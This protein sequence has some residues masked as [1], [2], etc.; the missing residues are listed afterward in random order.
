M[1]KTTCHKVHAYPYTFVS[2]PV[3]LAAPRSDF[4]IFCPDRNL[5]PK[6]TRKPKKQVPMVLRAHVN[7]VIKEKLAEAA[8][9]ECAYQHEAD[10]P[11]LVTRFQAKA[12]ETLS[13]GVEAM[14]T[15][16]FADALAKAREHGLNEVW[17]QHFMR[18]VNTPE[19]IM[20]TQSDPEEVI[21]E[22]KELYGATR[23]WMRSAS[24]LERR[25]RRRRRR[26]PT[27][28]SDAPGVRTHKSNIHK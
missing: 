26:I 4:D 16:V 18:A 1:P 3:T 14:I 10:A 28:C 27:T 25:R 9:R 19:H 7:E 24:R 8:N 5:R 21:K 22:A 6:Y 11:G 15:G 12:V 20:H 17:H 2:G 23:S 13:L